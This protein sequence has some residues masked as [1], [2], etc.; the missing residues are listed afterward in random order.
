MDSAALSLPPPQKPPDVQNV[1]IATPE[2][3]TDRIERLINIVGVICTIILAMVGIVG[4]CFGWHTLRTIQRQGL[5]MIRQTRVMRGQAQSMREQTALADKTAKAAQDSAKAAQD[6]VK[7]LIDSE[8]PWLL[9][10]NTVEPKGMPTMRLFPT[11]TEELA[12]EIKNFG[13]TPG[14]LV[15]WSVSVDVLEDTNIEQFIHSEIPEDISTGLPIPPNKKENFYVEWT[16]RDR[17]E[18]DD[19]RAGTKHLYVWGYVKYRSTVGGALSETHFCFHY[20][21][22]RNIRGRFEEGWA[23]EPRE[24]NYY[25]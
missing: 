23:W 22:R 8:R 14:W 5:T 18:I 10:S 17:S 3:T 21:R 2:K 25:S 24:E 7:V 11:Q 19:I 16:I 13:R 9:P 15:D 12:V 1:Y 20:S 4:I 6:S